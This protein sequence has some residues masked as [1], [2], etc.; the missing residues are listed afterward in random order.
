MLDKGAIVDIV[1][2]PPLI[3]VPDPE[4]PKILTSLHRAMKTSRLTWLT[5][6]EIGALKVPF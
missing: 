3:C 2:C 5:R 6:L 4:I 1:F